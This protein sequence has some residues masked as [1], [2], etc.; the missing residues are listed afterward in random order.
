LIKDGL[1][2]PWEHLARAKSLA[3]PSMDDTCIHSDIQDNM[4][5]AASVQMGVIHER[6]QYLFFL[7]PEIAISLS[8]G[9]EI[10]ISILL[11]PEI[12]IS[13]VSLL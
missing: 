8:L 1:N 7:G 12:A 13:P 6:V 3:H 11:G 9:P 2:D 5:H 4:E 10:A